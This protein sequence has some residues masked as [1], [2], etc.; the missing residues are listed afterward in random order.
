MECDQ[1]L[2]QQAP[3]LPVIDVLSCSTVDG[4]GLANSR[5]RCR[6][7]TTPR[8]DRIE[9]LTTGDWKQSRIAASEMTESLQ[10]QAEARQEQPPYRS[11]RV[12]LFLYALCQGIFPPHKISKTTGIDIKNNCPPGRKFDT[13]LRKARSGLP[14]MLNNT[15]TQISIHNLFLKWVSNM[16]AWR[17]RQGIK[18]K[19]TSSNFDSASTDGSRDRRPS[20]HVPEFSP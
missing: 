5:P 15:Q 12:A 6:V 17:L 1:R 10:Y 19:S 18:E 16:L 7:Q 8:S 20:S 13:G 2:Q 11:C 3:L 14:G 9:P 4:H